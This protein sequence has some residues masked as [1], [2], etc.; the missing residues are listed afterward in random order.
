MRRELNIYTGVNTK[1]DPMLVSYRGE[2]IINNTLSTLQKE[3]RRLTD[4]SF[5]SGG[6]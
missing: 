1:N 4:T 5:T 6:N 2:E 3:K